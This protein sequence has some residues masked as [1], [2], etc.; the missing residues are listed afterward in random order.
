[1]LAKELGFTPGEC[2]NIR[3]AGLLHDI[4]KIGIPDRV[5]NKKGKLDDEEYA[6]MKTHVTHGGEILKDFTLIEH[7][8]D[9]AMYH[10]EKWNGEGTLALDN[11][12]ISSTDR[13]LGTILGSCITE[14]YGSSLADD[15]IQI[16][17][18]TKSRQMPVNIF[19]HISPFCSSRH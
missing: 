16:S 13:S 2:E 9:G 11:V 12:Q 7:A 4:G 19:R 15:S 1:M 8:A 6:L 3:R 17:E 5:L 18:N 14:K 10:H